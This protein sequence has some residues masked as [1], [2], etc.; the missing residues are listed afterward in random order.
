MRNIACSTLALLACVAPISGQSPHSVPAEGQRIRVTAPDAGLRNR[1]G[2]FRGVHDGWLLVTADSSLRIPLAAIERID[3]YA[4]RQSHPWRG[5]GI[6]F[7]GGAALGFGLWYAADVGCYP[8]A[9][10][11]GCATVFGAFGGGV[12]G[13]L[14]GAVI[15]G[16]LLK[17]DRWEDAPLDGVRVGVAPSGNRGVVVRLTVRP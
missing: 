11:I 2:T 14:V 6:G 5:A 12:L 1:S 3:L 10:T 13:A 15:G 4:G 16:F 7:L 17:T 9:D 8:E